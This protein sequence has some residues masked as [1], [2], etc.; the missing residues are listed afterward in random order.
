VS[1]WIEFIL[2]RRALTARIGASP[3][4]F[5][6]T[7]RLWVAALAAAAAAWGIR[8]VLPEMHPILTAAA[9]LAPFGVV[10]LALCGRQN[11]P[12]RRR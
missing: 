8:L 6:Y 11:W 4:Q 12:V 1:G 2:L 5:G 9:T 7:I 3:S 10:Y